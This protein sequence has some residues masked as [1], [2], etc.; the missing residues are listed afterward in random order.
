MKTIFDKIDPK[1]IECAAGTCEHTQHA[2]NLPMYI[3]CAAILL[4]IAVQT[5]KTSN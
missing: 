1:Y 4:Y 2:M 3:I 5:L